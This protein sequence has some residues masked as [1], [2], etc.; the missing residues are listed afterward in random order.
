[1]KALA[2]LGFVAV[3][4]GVGIICYNWG[5]SNVYHDSYAATQAEREHCE[6]RISRMKGDP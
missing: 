1:M 5:A 6:D 3:L 4:C 2:I